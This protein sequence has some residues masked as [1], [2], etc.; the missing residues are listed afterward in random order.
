VKKVELKTITE[1]KA[2]VEAGRIVYD[3][4]PA[5]RVI[6]DSKGQWLIHCTLNGYTVGLHGIPGGPSEHKLN[7]PGPFYY[8]EDDNV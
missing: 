7:S 8:M 1:I 2:A 5:Y 6:K 3:G 4:N